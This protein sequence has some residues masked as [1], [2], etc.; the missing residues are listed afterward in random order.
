MECEWQ[1]RAV[2]PSTRDPR[3]QRQARNPDQQ[4]QATNGHQGTAGALK[5]DE[6]QTRDSDRQRPA[7][8][9]LQFCREN[10]ISSWSIALQFNERDSFAMNPGLARPGCEGHSSEL[11]AH[12]VVTFASKGRTKRIAWRLSA[13]LSL[14]ALMKLQT[15]GY[16]GRHLVTAIVVLF[17]AREPIER[18]NSSHFV[19]SF[20]LDVLTSCR[21]T[22]V[23]CFLQRIDL[24][25]GQR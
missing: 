16:P 12:A 23:A 25:A 17:E 1:P 5:Q 3:K 2:L 18:E 11:P 19:T 10:T 8:G 9:R 22:L 7:C 15:I 24:P 20:H 14:F 6:K 13:G 4:S 21:A